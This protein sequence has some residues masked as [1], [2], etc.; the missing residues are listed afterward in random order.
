MHPPAF[1]QRFL[2]EKQI[3]TIKDRLLIQGYIQG[4]ADA[5]DLEIRVGIF[6]GQVFLPGP[7]D[8]V[9]AAFTARGLT[10]ARGTK[11]Y[12]L[13]RGGRRVTGQAAD[14]AA[15]EVAQQVARVGRIDPNKLH[16]MF[17]N[18]RH[19]LQPLVKHFGSKEAAFLAIEDAVARTVMQRGITSR[20]EVEVVVAGR[21]VVARGNV[22]NGTPKIGT[23]FA[24]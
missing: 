16:H 3:R 17:G 1:V 9:V 18:P 15:R 20:F 5:A 22:V 24:K 14:T 10:L 7:E 13:C 6:V 8:L 19:A 2:Y 4:V 21:K 11:S 23:A 12:V